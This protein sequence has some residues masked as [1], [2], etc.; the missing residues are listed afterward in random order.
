MKLLQQR[1][2]ILLMEK[3]ALLLI[4]MFKR[5]IIICW[6]VMVTLI[7]IGMVVQRLRPYPI[8]ML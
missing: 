8:L 3:V 5:E 2:S 6:K 1:Q 4:L 7:Y